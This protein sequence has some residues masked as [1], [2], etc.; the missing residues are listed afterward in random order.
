MQHVILELVVEKGE[1]KHGRGNGCVGEREGGRG[2]G[3]RS[4]CNK[5]GGAEGRG[6][7]WR[8][9][10]GREGEHMHRSEV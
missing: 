10:D 8:I 3:T 4:A 9:V 5:L 1:W 7:G 2:E 6:G